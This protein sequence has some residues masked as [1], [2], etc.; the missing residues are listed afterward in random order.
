MP[1]DPR[2]KQRQSETVRGSLRASGRGKV[3]TVTSRRVSLGH[4]EKLESLNEEK[5]TFR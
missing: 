5:T 2:T 3:N 4:L 1:I